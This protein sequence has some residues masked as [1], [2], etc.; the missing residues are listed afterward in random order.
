MKENLPAT[1]DIEV[2]NSEQGLRGRDR[3]THQSC[4]I[5]IQ[6][7]KHKHG[8][9][10][11]FNARE[12]HNIL[13]PESFIVLVPAVNGIVHRR[14]CKWQGVRELNSGYDSISSSGADYQLCIGIELVASRRDSCRCAP[15]YR[16]RQRE[17]K[18]SSQVPP[19]SKFCGLEIHRQGLRKEPHDATLG[20]V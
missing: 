18:A 15:C 6:T 11:E 17:L 10:A 20:Q 13:K 8:L 19:K 7:S 1:F 5:T 14:S 9:S 12:P 3:I 16:H 2:A 4:L